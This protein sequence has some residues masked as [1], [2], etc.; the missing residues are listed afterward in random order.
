MIYALVAIAVWSLFLNHSASLAHLI[1]HG[2]PWLIGTRDEAGRP[3]KTLM[4]Q[5]VARAHRN[6]LENLVVFFPVA[7]LVLHAGHGEHPYAAAL[8]W[9]FLGARVGHLVF[10]AAGVPPLRSVTH[11]TGLCVYAGLF[12]I[13][14]GLI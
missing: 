4:E 7:L 13:L 8:A 2:L 1:Q 12:A 11:V 5:R 10:Y 9:T 3:D 6:H 14:L